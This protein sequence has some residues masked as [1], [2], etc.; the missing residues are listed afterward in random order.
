ML[1]S[2]SEVADRLLHDLGD[3][4]TLNYF[5]REVSYRVGKFRIK[6]TQPSK[7]GKDSGSK[8]LGLFWCIHELGLAGPW[9][10]S[11]QLGGNE[12]GIPHKRVSMPGSPG[13]SDKG[14]SDVETY[15]PAFYG[16][17]FKV[18]IIIL[19]ITF[20][21]VNTWSL[22]CVFIRGPCLLFEKFVNKDTY[23]YLARR[24]CVS[25][26]TR[27]LLDIEIWMYLYGG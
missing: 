19:Y 15:R 10:K 8:R 20:K 27:L 26:Y 25:Q 18:R 4:L 7:N 17:H 22:N 24:S 13:F 21:T 11:I 12:L 3:A 1:Q 23:R 9:L 14:S 6:K 2:W 5:R 16:A